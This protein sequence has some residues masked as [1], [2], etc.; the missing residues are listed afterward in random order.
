MGLMT[1]KMISK[2]LENQL[3]A[4]NEA[5]ASETSKAAEKDKKQKAIITE[6]ESNSASLEYQ[7]SIIKSEKEELIYRQTILDTE[8]VKVEAQLE[9]VKDVVLREKAF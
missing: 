4:S 9:L 2:E 6:L 7:L 1:L 8:I 5:K 3:K